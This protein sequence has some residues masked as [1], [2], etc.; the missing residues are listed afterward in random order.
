MYRKT[1]HKRKQKRR[2]MLYSY[3]FLCSLFC[4]QSEQKQAHFEPPTWNRYSGC[5][6][7][8]VSQ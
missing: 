1:K 7:S 6:F 5:N 8:G 4:S 3:I 2:A